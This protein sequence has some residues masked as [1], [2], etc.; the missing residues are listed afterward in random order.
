MLK[1]QIIFQSLFY[2][3]PLMGAVS[4]MGGYPAYH[5]PAPAYH[6][7][8]VYKE[9]PAPYQGGLQEYFC[10]KFIV[11]MVLNSEA[12]LLKACLS[13]ST[14]FTMTITALTSTLARCLMLMETLR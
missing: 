4:A 2:L 14:E 9:E 13:S 11:Q 1:V 10:L 7:A 8:P 12:K 6:Q 5:P 3:L